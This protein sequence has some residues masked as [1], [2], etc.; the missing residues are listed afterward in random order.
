VKK[1][2]QK[3]KRYEKKTRCEGKPTSRFL[4][5]NLIEPTRMLGR[6]GNNF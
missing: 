6:P 1:N 5:Q 2:D 3:Y 4:K